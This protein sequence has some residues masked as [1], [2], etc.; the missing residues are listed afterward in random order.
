[1]QLDLAPRTRGRAAQPAHAE[2]VGEVTLDDLA[3]LGIEKGSKSS[4]LARITDS[5]HAVARTLAQGASPHDAAVICG[6]SSSRIS[7]LLADPAFKEL[8]AF[9][10]ARKVEAFGSLVERMATLGLDTEAELRRRLEESP[11]DFK[12][13]D[14]TKLLE[15]VADRTGAGPKSTQVNVNVDIAARFEAAKARVAKLQLEGAA[16]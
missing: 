12:V 4:A 5:H 3:T 7:I 15:T 2:P 10:R 8:L 9:Y 11:D 6:Y 13:A 1:M 14:L 16:Q